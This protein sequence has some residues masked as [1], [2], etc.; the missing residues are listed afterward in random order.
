[1]E[2][3]LQSFVLQIFDRNPKPKGEKKTKQ[4]KEVQEKEYVCCFLLTLFFFF[5]GGDFFQQEKM[6][7]TPFLLFHKIY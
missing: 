1:V 7:T 2:R 6:G 3:F 4:N 5:L